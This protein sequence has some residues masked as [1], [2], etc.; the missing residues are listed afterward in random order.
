[1][2][3]R[4][5]HF[6]GSVPAEVSAEPE[7]VMRWLLGSAGGHELTALPCEDPRWIAPWL[8]G[9]RDVVDGARAE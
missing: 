4:A 1:M 2:L 9:R 6:V 8:I 5:L 7:G 3:N